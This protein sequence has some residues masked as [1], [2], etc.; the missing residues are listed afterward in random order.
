LTNNSNQLNSLIEKQ[1]KTSDHLVEAIK[2]LKLNR[3]FTEEQIKYL[4]KLNKQNTLIKSWGTDG[5]YLIRIEITVA[6][7]DNIRARN[8]GVDWEGYEIFMPTYKK[9]IEYIILKKS[10]L[11]EKISEELVTEQVNFV[12]LKLNMIFS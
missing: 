10:G 9:E 5:E 12:F 3:I 11:T 8:S 7:E 4:N 1:N 2:I 6:D